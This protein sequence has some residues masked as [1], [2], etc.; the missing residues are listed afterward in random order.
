MRRWGLTG[1]RWLIRQWLGRSFGGGCGWRRCFYGWRLIGHQFARG[2]M[3]APITN[4][5]FLFRALGFAAVEL[6]EGITLR[7]IVNELPP[8]PLPYAP[9][10]AHEVTTNRLWLAAA[11]SFS[12]P[13]RE[14]TIFTLSRLLPGVGNHIIRTDRDACA[15]GCSGGLRPPSSIDA[16]ISVRPYSFYRARVST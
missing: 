9:G 10:S 3:Q 15:F 6:A 12:W 2:T 5:P 11:S 13:A 8:Q 7:N 14:S 16:S 1:S 4:L